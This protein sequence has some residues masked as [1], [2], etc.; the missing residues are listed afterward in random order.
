MLESE[1]ESEGEGEGEFSLSLLLSLSP[2]LIII[3]R[4]VWLVF[5]P[6]LSFPFQIGC[7]R[8][9]DAPRGVAR[10]RGGSCSKV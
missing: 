1:G 9:C 2:S 8:N 3:L 10:E 7:L 5:N 6:P 4:S